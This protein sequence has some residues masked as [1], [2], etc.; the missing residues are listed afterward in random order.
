MSSACVPGLFITDLP[1]DCRPSVNYRG[2]WLC[3][4]TSE[5]VYDN[6]VESNMLLGI[7][8]VTDRTHLYIALCALSNRRPVTGGWLPSRSLAAR[9]FTRGIAS[10]VRGRRDSPVTLQRKTGRA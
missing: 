4:N 5:M 10:P 9:S 7:E 6:G 8:D 1:T 2:R 3:L